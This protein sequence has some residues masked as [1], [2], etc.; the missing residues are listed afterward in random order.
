MCAVF[1]NGMSEV[2]STEQRLCVGDTDKT[3]D[4]PSVVH[5]DDN[6]YVCHV[7]EHLQ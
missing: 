3:I 4:I 6:K 5:F 1:N 2:V 7:Q